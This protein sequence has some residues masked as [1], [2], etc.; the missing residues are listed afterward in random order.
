[1]KWL[2]KCLMYVYMKLFN[3][4]FIIK[5]TSVQKISVVFKD[6]EF[7]IE[8]F[9]SHIDSWSYQIFRLLYK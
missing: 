8:F 4:I 6:P 9:L 3:V 2:I 7:H 1:M 5:Y